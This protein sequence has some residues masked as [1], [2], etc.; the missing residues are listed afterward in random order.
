MSI[1]EQY[2]EATSRTT[3]AIEKV[4]DFWTQGART[5]SNQ[6]LPGLP[7][8]DL[9]P[10]VERYFEFVQRTVDISRDVSIKFAEAGNKLSGVA[11]ERV[12]SA[13]SVV[14]EQAESARDLVHEQAGKAERAAREQAEKAEQA[15]RELA[16]EA[17]KAERDQARQAHQKARERYEGKTKAEL[18]DLLD[19]RDL[20]K[21]GT[22]DELIERLVEA[23]SK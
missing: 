13:G 3:G 6:W 12:E 21:T 19:R 14:R 5:L 8:V 10:A 2:S 1:T 22:V 18:S 4:T 15:E 11:R 16:R 7:Q 17:R 9:I 23:D 20:P